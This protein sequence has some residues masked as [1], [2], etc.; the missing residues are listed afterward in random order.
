VKTSKPQLVLFA[1][2]HLLS[3]LALVRMKMAADSEVF[4]A[5]H[6]VRSGVLI[7]VRALHFTS[8]HCSIILMESTPYYI[9]LY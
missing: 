1:E 8:L 9:L 4:G 6:G 5:G 2:V 7:L 3:V